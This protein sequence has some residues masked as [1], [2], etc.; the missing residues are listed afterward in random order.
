[1]NPR[2]RPHVDVEQRS[3][4]AAPFHG[5][6]LSRAGQRRSCRVRGIRRAHPARRPALLERRAAGGLCR[7][8]H[9]HESDGERMRRLARWSFGIPALIL[10]GSCITPAQSAPSPTATHAQTTLPRRATPPR[11]APPVLPRRVPDRSGFSYAGSLMQGGVVI[12]TAPSG[13]SLLM[14]NGATI[15]VAPD[16]QFVIGFDR[17]AGAVAS[18]VATLEDGRQVR[19]TLAIAPRQWNISRLFG[20]QRGYKNGEAGSYHSGLDVAVP[21]GTPVLA[22]ADGVVI[23]AADHPFTLEGNLLMVA[24]GMGLNSAILHLSRIV[25]H[26][27]EHVRRGETIAFSGMTGRATGPHLHWSIKWRDAKLDPLL[28]AGP[29]PHTR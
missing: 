28:V 15:P 13:T 27:G 4:G 5:Q 3:P 9:R 6:R 11:D 26:V 23:L 16:G 25:V 18:L 14:F 24:H 7:R 1:M 22:P 20:S 10:L 12:G 8:R 19:D 21:Q 2:D 17:D 29:M